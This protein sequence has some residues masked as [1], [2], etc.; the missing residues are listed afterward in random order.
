MRRRQYSAEK[1][2]AEKA[3]TASLWVTFGFRVRMAG[4]SMIRSPKLLLAEIDPQAH[5][6]GDQDPR[7][8][9]VEQMFRSRFSLEVRRTHIRGLE[10]LAHRRKRQSG[11]LFP[12]GGRIHHANDDQH[13]RADDEHR[14]EERRVGKECRSRWS[15]YH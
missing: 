1:P 2:G 6:C 3:R 10:F 12:L 4:M 13:G 9:Q 7:K 5:H 8:R 15:P 14:S 11:D